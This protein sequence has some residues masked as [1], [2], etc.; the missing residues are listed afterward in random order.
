ML[1]RLGSTDNM[2]VAP[3]TDFHLI[4][5]FLSNATSI[6][7]TESSTSPVCLPRFNDR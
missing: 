5:N 1:R 4:V 6:K 7:Q 3:A 2:C